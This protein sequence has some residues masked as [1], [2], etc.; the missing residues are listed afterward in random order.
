M[1]EQ[2]KIDFSKEI[3]RKNLQKEIAE[4][5]YYHPDLYKKWRR[6]KIELENFLKEKPQLKKE[7]IETYED[8]LDLLNKSKW[9]SWIYLS[10]TETIALFGE[11]LDFVLSD[12]TYPL[13]K[14]LSLFL[15]EVLILSVRDEYKSKIRDEL[16]NNQEEIS[17][18]Y[19]VNNGKKIIPNVANWLKYYNQQLGTNEVKNVD[20]ASFLAKDKNVMGLSQKE[21]KKIKRLFK[22][23]EELKIS[24]LTV[25]GLEEEE[26]WVGDTGIE[27]HKRDKVE[28]IS[29]S[30]I[31]RKGLNKEV[32]VLPKKDSAL[33]PSYSINPSQATS[34]ILES[35]SLFSSDEVLKKRF[36]NII[37]SAVCGVRSSTET[38]IVLKRSQ[39]IGGL[40]LEQETVD[41]IMNILREKIGQPETLIK[42][43][44]KFIGTEKVKA[45]IKAPSKEL[46]EVETKV[47]QL[48]N[49]KTIVEETKNIKQNKKVFTNKK[50]DNIKKEKITKDIEEAVKKFRPKEVPVSPIIMSSIQSLKKQAL[51]ENVDKEKKQ[52]KV[53]PIIK[54][55]EK[56]NLGLSKNNPI[57]SRSSVKTAK[58]MVEGVSDQPK[59]YGPS[60]ELRS[61][62]LIDWRRWG[63]SQEAVAKI[64]GKM[65]LLAEDSLLKKAEG[66]KAWKESEI[67]KLYLEIGEESINKGR[68]IETII[69]E[70]QKEDRKTLTQEEFN[71]VIELN[72][73]LRF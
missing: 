11:G 25:E 40:G 4:G 58:T 54:N 45:L 62:S 3:I 34:D 14:N 28:N 61:I 50:E 41:K 67:N 49:P 8:C 66:I 52:K 22:L 20:M 38:A 13:E 21:S 47:Q 30:T 23:Y 10:T 56:I 32:K 26:Y 69:N 27:L 36:K 37:F 5:F 46:L 43:K 51:D 15:L 70:R 12:E 18:E 24:A 55:P 35:L 7:N 59:I 2:T 31:I 29:K 64:L 73:K 72:Q 44:E 39:K 68:S 9:F 48:I 1:A 57:L 65:N 42:K 71:A 53:L 63:T 60:D 19:I 6:V 17:H 33:L 16:L